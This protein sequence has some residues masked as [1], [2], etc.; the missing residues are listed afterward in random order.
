MGVVFFQDGELFSTPACPCAYR[1][2][3]GGDARNWGR[4]PPDLGPPGTGWLSPG[5]LLRIGQR[6]GTV[7]RR[8]VW[9]FGQFSPVAGRLG[10]G[11]GEIGLG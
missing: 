9:G 8:A 6:G 2:G 10:L 1:D 7:F 4:W 11:G 3:T 5:A